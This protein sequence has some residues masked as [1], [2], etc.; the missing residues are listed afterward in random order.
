MILKLT[1]SLAKIN[2][3]EMKASLSYFIP[4]EDTG[5]LATIESF[6][7]ASC[8]AIHQIVSK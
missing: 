4:Q 1:V 7:L 5:E 3:L 6:Q 8:V 2:A